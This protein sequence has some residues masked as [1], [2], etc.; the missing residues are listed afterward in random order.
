MCQLRRFA[1]GVRITERF[2]FRRDQ[3]RLVRVIGAAG[4]LRK[5]I[6][7][8]NYEPLIAEQGYIDGMRTYHQY[9]CVVRFYM[10]N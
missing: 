4:K 2:T 6:A 10:I 8:L 7:H 1:L 3:Q 5:K 9:G